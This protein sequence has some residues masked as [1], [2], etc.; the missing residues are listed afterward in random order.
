MEENLFFPENLE[1]GASP[2]EFHT[3]GIE[4]ELPDESRISQWVAA[5][6]QSEN[7]T[8]QH[9]TYI[10]CDDAYLLDLNEQYLN[11][12]TLTDIITFH[13]SKLPQIEGDIFISIER[14]HENAQ[15]YQ[16]TFDQELYRVI[17]HGVLH[18]CGYSDKTPTDKALMTEKENKALLQLHIL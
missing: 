10:F 5:V 17:I 14:V 1:E 8:L 3:E 16:V 18:L 13:Y 6:I 12:D 4:F 11:H 9:I 2:I 15:T 7:K